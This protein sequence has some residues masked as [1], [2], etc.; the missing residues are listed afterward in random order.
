MT[1]A[2]ATAIQTSSVG[3]KEIMGVTLGGYAVGYKVLP[4]RL[5]VP[6][7]RFGSSAVAIPAKKLR[8][9]REPVSEPALLYS[10]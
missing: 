10:E 9:G 2:N 1:M 6:R 3:M 4:I 8:P 7:V 5:S